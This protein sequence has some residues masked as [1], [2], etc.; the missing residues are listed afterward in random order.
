MIVLD[1]N[2]ISELMRSQPEAK[3]VAWVNARDRRDLFTTA[4]TVAELLS[5]I[6]QMPI[7]RRREDL[8]HTANT[9]LEDGFRGRI[10]PFDEYCARQFGPIYAHTALLG[11]E[12]K[13]RMPSLPRF[14]PNTVSP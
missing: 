12:W 8:S 6:A 5:G 11:K 4:I 1:T 3:V 9:M 14:A 2:V 13:S 7:G 10:L